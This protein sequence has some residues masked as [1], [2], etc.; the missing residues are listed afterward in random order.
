M[1]RVDRISAAM[2]AGGSFR[3][4]RVALLRDYLG[5][6]MKADVEAGRIQAGYGGLAG[7][8]ADRRLA[9][10]AC[11]G[12]RRWQA[13]MSR[14]RDMGPVECRGTATLAGPN[15]RAHLAP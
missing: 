2:K 10:M 6:L 1:F 15:V 14:Y 13:S 11:R 12:T 3:P 4:R 8:V 5:E 9:F 7:N